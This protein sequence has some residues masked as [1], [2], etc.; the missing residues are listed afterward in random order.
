MIRQ[1]LATGIRRPIQSVSKNT[2]FDTEICRRLESEWAVSSRVENQSLSPRGNF[3]RTCKWSAADISTIYS[4][5][6]GPNRCPRAIATGPFATPGHCV[7]EN[8]GL[9]GRRHFAFSY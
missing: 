5:S 4:G 8:L 1:N 3:R 9:A 6:N 7:V 2:D